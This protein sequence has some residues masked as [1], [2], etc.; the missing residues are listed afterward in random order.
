MV[1]DNFVRNTEPIRS[2]AYLCLGAVADRIR[3][4]KDKLLKQLE[5]KEMQIKL[6][7]DREHR[8]PVR[9]QQSQDL[10]MSTIRWNKLP[11]STHN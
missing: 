6:I 9:D 8:K 11:A 1:R 10:L 4:E 3:N 5:H 7:K 2:S